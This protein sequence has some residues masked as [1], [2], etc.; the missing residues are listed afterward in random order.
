MIAWNCCGFTSASLLTEGRNEGRT[1]SIAG[2]DALPRSH[3]E[4]MGSSR[5]RRAK[6]RQQIVPTGECLRPELLE[7]GGRRD[8]REGEQC[9]SIFIFGQLKTNRTAIAPFFRVPL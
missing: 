2:V 4:V 5:Q 3:H 7:A 6:Q 9:A 1:T 8:V